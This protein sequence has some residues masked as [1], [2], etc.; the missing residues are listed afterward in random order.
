[1]LSSLVELHLPYCDL[2]DLL[3][4][5][6]VVNFS[7]IMVINLRS[8][9]FNSPLPRW[10][11]NISTFVELDLSHCGIKDS[12]N[13][14][15]AWENLYL[16]HSLALSSNEMDGEIVKLVESLSKCRNNSLE[17]LDLSSND[18]NG[19]I[20]KSLQNLNNMSLL[21]AANSL[22]PKP[23]GSHKPCTP[24]PVLLCTQACNLLRPA[25]IVCT[26]SASTLLCIN[27]LLPLPSASISSFLSSLHSPDP[28]HRISTHHP[29]SAPTQ[30]LLCA[31]LHTVPRPQS[32]ASALLLATAPS[33]P[34]VQKRQ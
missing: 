19:L 32:R 26:E 27:L 4:F 12:L 20:P 22:L 15:D 17:E 25:Q 7:F 9:N 5:L 33:L 34:H 13:N 10:L 6:L 23:A 31:P 18:F 11:L 8:N 16:L 2:H 1:M 21:L 29:P 28:L 24:A 3:T 14:V 30:P